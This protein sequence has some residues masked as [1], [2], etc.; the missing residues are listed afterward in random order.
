MPAVA[1]DVK[2]DEETL[3][4]LLEAADALSIAARA[5]FI[6]EEDQSGAGATTGRLS[7]VEGS[8]DVVKQAAERVLEDAKEY[9]RART[10]GSLLEEDR[11]VLRAALRALKVDVLGL[12][13]EES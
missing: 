6:A 13:H 12:E 5:R 10:G 8:A 1:A 7:R 11:H 2:G 3:A 9:D 4:A